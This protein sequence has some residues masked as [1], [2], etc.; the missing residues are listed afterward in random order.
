MIGENFFLVSSDGTIFGKINAFITDDSSTVK[1]NDLWD[2]SFT[3][4]KKDNPCYDLIN[5]GMFIET[6][7]VSFKIISPP[8]LKVDSTGE[9]KMIDSTSCKTIECELLQYKLGENFKINTGEEDSYEYLVPSNLDEFGVR[10][11]QIVIYDKNNPELSLMHIILQGVPGWKVGYIDPILASKNYSFSGNNSVYGFLKD[12]LQKTAKCLVSFDMK[13][14]L[15]NMVK[16]EDVGTDTGIVISLKTLAKELNISPYEKEIYT[17]YKVTGADGLTIRD[18]NFGSDTITN[19]D[20][21]MRSPW[22]Q[23]SDKVTT[24]NGEYSLT[25]APKTTYVNDSFVKTLIANVMC[26]DTDI[27]T[28]LPQRAFSWTRVSSDA[29][30]DA[31]WNRFGHY[32]NT[33]RLSMSDYDVGCIFYCEFYINDVINL[34]DTEGHTIYDTNNNPITTLIPNLVLHTEITLQSIIDKY[35]SYKKVMETQRPLYITQARNYATALEKSSDLYNRQPIDHVEYD[36]YDYT[37]EELNTELSKYNDL[38]AVV[39]SNPDYQT[40]GVFDI[41]RLKQYLA[42]Y[43]Y[44][45]LKDIVSDITYAIS[46]YNDKNRKLQKSWETQW[47]LFGISELQTR[48][49]LYKEQVD[50]MS[51]YSKP[52]NNLSEAEKSALGITQTLYN[53]YNATYNTAN[54]NLTNCTAEY[55]KKKTQYDTYIS[56]MNTCQS[57]MASIA[58]LADLSNSLHGFTQ[59]EI[60][61]IQSFYNQA[62]YSDE[63]FLVDSSD[64]T[65][66]KIDVEL[67]LYNAAKEDLYEKS[68]LQVEFTTTIENILQ[69]PEFACFKDYL[70]VGNFCLVEDNDG[71]F[72]KLRIVSMTY[73]PISNDVEMS[74]SFSTM[75]KNYYGVS[76]YNLILDSEISSASK[77]GGSSSSGSSSGGSNGD[78]NGVPSYLIKALLNSNFFNGRFDTLKAQTILAYAAEI[79]TLL[80]NYIKTDQIVADSAI[81]KQIQTIT[82]TAT[83][84]TAF[85]SFVDDLLANHVTAK[86]I[87]GEKISTN[88]FMVGS[89][90]GRLLIQDST[91]SIKDSNNVTRVQ[92]GKDANSNFSFIICDASGTGTIIDSNGVTERGIANGL[93]KAEKLANRSE[94]Y[95]GISG[96]K[97]NIDSVVTSINNGNTTISSAKVYFD[98]VNKS[99]N[100]MISEMTTKY[101]GV[102]ESLSNNYYTKTETNNQ[103]T[104]TIGT[105]T[106][107]KSNGQIVL[108]KDALNSVIDTATSH[109][110]TISLLQ[111]DLVNKATTSS[112]STLSADLTGFKTTVSNTYATQN[113]LSLLGSSVTQSMSDFKAEVKDIYIPTAVAELGIYSVTLTS[114]TG[115]TYS[116]DKMSKLISAKVVQSETNIT[117]DL[118]ERAFL[119]TRKS[120]DPLADERWNSLGHYGK[121]LAVTSADYDDDCLFCCDVTLTESEDLL[122]TDGQP[123]TDTMGDTITVLVPTD[124]LHA[125]ISMQA[126]TKKM[127]STIEVLSNRINLGVDVNGKLTAIG[128]NGLKNSVEIDS[129]ILQLTGALQSANYMAGSTGSRLNLSDGSFVSKNLSWDSNGTLTANNGVFNGTVNATNGNIADFILSSSGMSRT[130]DDGLNTIMLRPIQPNKS[131]GVFYIGTRE[132]VT[133]PWTYP[134]RLN[135]DGSAVFTR[136]KI[137]DLTI[138]DNGINNPNEIKI[139]KSVLELGS[140]DSYTGVGNLI[141]IN[142]AGLTLRNGVNGVFLDTS[143]LIIGG[144]S[145]VTT[146]AF[147]PSSI[148]FKQGDFRIQSYL[149]NLVGGDF[150]GIKAVNSSTPSI[151]PTHDNAFILGSSSYRWKQLYAVTSTISTSDS[152]QKQFPTEINQKYVDFFMKLLPKVFQFI[153]NDSGRWHIGFYAQEVETALEESKLTSLDFAGFIK[154]PIYAKDSEGIETDVV[155]D[156]LYGLRYEEFIALITKVL[157]IVKIKQDNMESRLT[158]LEERQGE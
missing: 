106:I 93:I 112:V 5:V 2:F 123:I 60:E 133:D 131:Y 11:Q 144:Y 108:M 121:T 17:K 69:I 122:D 64:T 145:D 14:K 49:S 104:T 40:N 52:W 33:L 150:G 94:T 42:Y 4:Y 32:G 10:K 76:D 1:L 120:I 85:Q 158:A 132:S 84:T 105:T 129:S 20:Y 63:N 24:Q 137:G 81:M 71:V 89:S 34:T 31:E 87:F 28:L 127:K 96:D 21:Y 90:D 109:T 56:Q 98:S 146:Y 126:S 119:W 68:Q 78:K 156:Y 27:T 7:K 8:E 130:S 53:S 65:T 113:A 155:I 19:I 22:V 111:Q 59:Q 124:I 55:N 15:I 157:Q 66:S 97:L 139:T 16:I 80:T 61:L 77:S 140:W 86:A 152:R 135:G 92:I 128:I 74:I 70:E 51:Q 58:L 46:H 67:D 41:N 57:N 138:D 147:Y 116:E 3:V 134:V 153:D 114:D 110:Q 82:F 83:T 103:I 151:C 154:S 142:K 141:Q 6:E 72:H 148:V 36:W 99:L 102:S 75:I 95:S 100:T 26:S 23:E 101:D 37:T 54:T 35:T 62:D 29:S 125:E 136:G 79:N 118:P 149:S 91:I 9:Y 12:D 143:G 107:T 50:A 25:I 43:N 73:S 47:E 39:E 44:I 38:I 18:V 88:D 117:P 48:M 115:N 13:N 30:S 45:C